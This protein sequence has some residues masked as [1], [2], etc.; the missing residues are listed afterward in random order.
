ML[1]PRGRIVS[2]L[3]SVLVPVAIDRP[4]TYASDRLL[5]PGTIVAVPLGTRV[6]IG[7]VQD[8]TVAT[9]SGSAYVYNLAG[10][11]PTTP[12][13]VL[14]K[15]V[16]A[17]SDFFG[18][19]VAISGTRVVVGAHSDD[20]GASNAGAAF[21]FDLAGATP[22]VPV[23]KLQNPSAAID[24]N[25]GGSVAIFGL[26]T[27]GD[28]VDVKV[29]RGFARR[30]GPGGVGAELRLSRSPKCAGPMGSAGAEGPPGAD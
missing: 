24:D 14:K 22:A 9:D 29:R 12:V 16:P 11:T 20:T 7:G 30:V 25:F 5:P 6:V 10:T 26:G 21:V 2:H 15:T 19:S 17:A 28:H 4:Y 13:A 8:D 3:G 27:A 18:V 23:T 1:A